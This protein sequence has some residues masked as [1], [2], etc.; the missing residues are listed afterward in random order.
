MLD[1][2][3]VRELL[4]YDP[5]TGALTWR[6]RGR[7]WF[8]SDHD[9]TRWNAR[10]SGG[11]AGSAPKKKRGYVYVRSPGRIHKAHRVIWLWMTGEWPRDQ[12]DHINHDRADNRWCNLR[13][14]TNADNQKNVSLRA[15]NTSGA[16][17]V[18][19]HTHGDKWRAQIKVGGRFIHLGLFDDKTTAI[20]ARQA[21]NEKYGF[22]ANHGSA[23]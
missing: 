11:R 15:D 22:H 18:R 12:V 20:A 8:K 7:K 17:G 10:F 23:R 3:A 16:V 9:Q 14:A 4:D 19:R 1:L 21:A 13:A 2:N 6:E 5:E